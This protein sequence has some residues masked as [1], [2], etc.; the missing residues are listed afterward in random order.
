MALNPEHEPKSNSNPGYV[1][2]LH[3]V[4]TERYKIGRAIQGRLKNR[5][6]ELNRQQAPFPIEIIGWIEVSDCDAAEKSLQQHFSKY[7]AHG[8][9]F[10]FRKDELDEICYAYGN[11]MAKY[12][13]DERLC[14]NEDEPPIAEEY[15]FFN[16]VNNYC[17]QYQ[18]LN[19]PTDYPNSY[20]ST[21]Q[22]SYSGTSSSGSDTSLIGF[23]TIAVIGLVILAIMNIGRLPK[24]P[25]QTMK[26][27][28][29]SR[30][31]HIDVLP[32]DG[33]FLPNHRIDASVIGKEAAFIRSGPDDTKYPAIGQPLTNGTPIKTLKRSQNGWFFVQTES[34]NK[35]WVAGNL[36]R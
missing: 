12:W 27:G 34:G 21:Y 35:G 33:R 8:E 17:K 15:D 19:Q 18:Q 3:A 14:E 23:M 24:I 5:T 22:S 20:P 6:Q 13:I 26:D 32:D 36:I 30:I 9:W 28:G 16:S 29:Q 1:Y 25:S 7:C 2:F 31:S 4:G 11:V 10:E